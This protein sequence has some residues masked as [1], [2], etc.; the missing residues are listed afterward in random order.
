[1]G[2]IAEWLNGLEVGDY[3]AHFAENDI[4]FSML[5]ELTDQDLEKLDRCKILRAIAALERATEA[6]RPR[7]QQTRRRPG[8]V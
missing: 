5:P 1:M 2:E 8:F 4:D 3:V 6:Y 7:Q